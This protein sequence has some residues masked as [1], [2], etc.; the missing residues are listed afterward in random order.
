MGG[1]GWGGGGMRAV[2]TWLALLA[3]SLALSFLLQAAELPAALLLGP[4]AAGIGFGVL[5]VRARVPRPLFTTA[6]GVI[7]CLIAHAV[8]A[9]VLVDIARNWPD[10]LLAVACTIVASALVGWLLARFGTLPGTSAAWGSSPGAAS[11]MTAMAEAY[12]ADPRLVAFMQ[13]IRVICVV[14][15]ASVVSRALIGAAPAALPPAAMPEEL[16]LVLGLAV[17]LVLAVAGSWLGGRLRLPAGGLLMPLVLGALL[18]ATGLVAITLPQSLLGAAYL[19]I[20]W[21]VGLQ[22]N[23][24]T[25]QHSLFALPQVVLGAFG[26]I[27]LCGGAAWLLVL[28]GRTDPLTAFLATSPGGIDSVAIIAVGG[29]ADIA[30]VLALQTLRLLVV[31]LVGP[32]LAKW[33]ARGAARSATRDLPDGR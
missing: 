4:M 23:R 27:A 16:H 20:G 13:Y 9:E 17:T 33:I 14:V 31:L 29:H 12:G 11:A 25:L 6:Q 30:F 24:A 32:P 28:F 3:A 18:N 22:F 19:V 5:G 21:Y 10:M 26:M 8:T 15:T 1:A 2:V 7:G